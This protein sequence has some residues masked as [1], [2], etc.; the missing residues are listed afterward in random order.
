MKKHKKIYIFIVFLVIMVVIFIGSKI[1]NINKAKKVIN[2]TLTDLKEI[3]IEEVNKHMS[4]SELL[5]VLD[6]NLLDAEKMQQNGL[7][8]LFFEN[9]D[10]TIED[11]KMDDNNITA[12]MNITNKDFKIII[13]NWIK[14]IVNE[15]ESGNN[16]TEEVCLEK[17][18]E[19]AS[20]SNLSTKTVTKMITLEKDNDWRII[21]NDEL[22]N[23]IFPGI[24]SVNSVIEGM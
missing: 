13:T 23:A 21:V 6:E 22:V 3:N 10:W 9:L 12:T 8:K 14:E 15:K 20:D 18:K 1:S 4:Y 16:L 24:E 17:L 5:N 19:C 7:D 2:K 11:I